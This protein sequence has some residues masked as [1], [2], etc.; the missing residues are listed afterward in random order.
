MYLQ[1]PAYHRQWQKYGF[2]PDDWAGAG[3][4]RLVES[5]VACGDAEAIRRRIDSHIDAGATAIKILPHNP[6]GRGPDWKLLEAFA[7]GS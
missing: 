7:P 3:S 1:L 5:L 2:G 4:D 6:S